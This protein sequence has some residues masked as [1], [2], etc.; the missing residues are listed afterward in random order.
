MWMHKSPVCSDLHA[1]PLTARPGDVNIDAQ[2]STVNSRGG[3]MAQEARGLFLVGESRLDALIRAWP[4]CGT[5]LSGTPIEINSTSPLT[6]FNLQAPL[7]NMDQPYQIFAF[8]T[9]ASHSDLAG[10]LSDLLAMP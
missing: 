2:Q 4:C 9:K 7:T 5:S 1:C 8:T 6:N 3:I 10:R